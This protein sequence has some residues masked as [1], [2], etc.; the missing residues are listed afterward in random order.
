MTDFD[1]IIIDQFTSF[2]FK[3]HS[4]ETTEVGTINEFKY[5]PSYLEDTHYTLVLF[6][7][8]KHDH[9][10][11]RLY[12]HNNSDGS[13]VSSFYQM[14]NSTDWNQNY[15]RENIEEIYTTEIRMATINEI[16]HND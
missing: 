16:L 1:K 2:G 15:I 13:Y 4:C 6:D 12:M 7:Y 11:H 14:S 10:D 9:A 3:L 8:H 5:F